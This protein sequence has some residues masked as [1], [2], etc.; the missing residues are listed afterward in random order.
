MKVPWAAMLGLTATAWSFEG[1][2]SSWDETRGV[3][4]TRAEETLSYGNP[5]LEAGEAGVYELRALGRSESRWL[6]TLTGGSPEHAG[7][8]GST[9][10]DWS[11]MV[12]RSEAHLTGG[13]F[14][15]GETLA[16][17]RRT[18]ESR[19]PGCTSSDATRAEGRAESRDTDPDTEP[20][21]SPGTGDVGSEPC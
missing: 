9:Y 1:D 16:A 5:G 17:D 11:R 3:E 20:T 18:G 7:P 2:W 4:E 8:A 12:G 19:S 10:F 15:T 13:I 21:A 14:R 6:G